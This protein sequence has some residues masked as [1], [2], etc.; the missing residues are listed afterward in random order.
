MVCILLPPWFIVIVFFPDKHG[1]TLTSVVVTG[2]KMRKGVDNVF[3]FVT[4]FEANIRKK[5]A[6][7]NPHSIT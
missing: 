1:L 7:P 2:E 4:L 6:Q 3:S 5:F